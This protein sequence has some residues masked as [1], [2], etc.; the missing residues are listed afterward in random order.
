MGADVGHL[1]G[2]ELLG[3]IKSFKENWGFI[4]S[5]SFSGDLFVHLRSNKQLGAVSAGDLVQ[6]EVEEDP[7]SAGG[8][9]A[10]NATLQRRDPLDL[11]GQQVQGWVKSFR[12]GWGFLNSNRFE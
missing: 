1:L 10:V 7:Q 3:E 6:F 4:V 8:F 9:H 12:S 2:Q 11:V 5:D